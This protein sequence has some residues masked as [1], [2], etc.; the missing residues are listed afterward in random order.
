[1][2]E[3]S[4]ISCNYCGYTWYKLDTGMDTIEP[5]CIVCGDTDLRLHRFTNNDPFGYNY[6]KDDDEL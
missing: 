5:A 1:M 2:Q 4:K 3:R 6:G